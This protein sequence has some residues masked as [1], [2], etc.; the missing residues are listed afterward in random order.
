MLLWLKR[1]FIYFILLFFV[2]WGLPLSA[3]SQTPEV[4]TNLG[5]YGGQIY[6]ITLDPSTPDKVFAGSFKGDGLYVTIDGG[7]TWQAVVATEEVQ[8][9]DTFKNHAV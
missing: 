7:A 6:D 8:G 3:K 4:W 2:L 1:N 9:E 5:L